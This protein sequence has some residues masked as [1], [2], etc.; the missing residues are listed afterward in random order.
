MAIKLSNY[1]PVDFDDYAHDY[2]SA[3]KSRLWL[4]GETNDY[5]YTYKLNCLKRWAYRYDLEGKI[6]DFGCGI[7][8]LSGLLAQSFPKSSI[9]GY[10]ISSKSIHLAREKWEH[11]QNLTF[12]SQLPNREFDLIIVAN[13]FH[14]IKQENR[15]DTLVKIRNLLKTDGSLIVFEH[16]PYNPFTRIVVKSCQFDA[17]A[18]LLSLGRFIKLALNCSFNIALK[19]Y[20]VF[21]PIPLRYLRKFEPFLGFL[22]LGAQ[23]ML[24]LNPKSK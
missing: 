8:E 6:L 9:C 2:E 10:D 22:P 16:N 1:Q 24:L 19:R 12:K 14:H 18:D 23:Y 4:S 13:V 15:R 3:L 7:G 20:I 21:F 5:F 17:D 11:L